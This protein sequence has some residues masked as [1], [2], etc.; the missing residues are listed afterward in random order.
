MS[1]IKHP[2]VDPDVT[3]HTPVP[4][5]IQYS[6]H[7]STTLGADTRFSSLASL[8]MS[9][10]TDTNALEKAQGPAQTRA[11]GTA[12][13]RDT[14]LGQVHTDIDNICQGVQALVDAN[15]GQAEEY[16]TAAAMHL[17]KS[18]RSPKPWLAAK[19]V[20]GTPGAALVKAKMVKKGASYEWQISS[21]G[22]TWT[23]VGFSTRAD[24]TVTGLSAGSTYSFRFR[25]TKGHVTGDFSQALTFMA[26]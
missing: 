2:L 12:A 21:D 8:V 9:L 17:R 11:K 14:P 13:A 19:M 5:V 10:V 23:T 15:P 16:A 4:E 20:P 3:R 24:M 18:N 22:K 25:T 1:T 26:H 6:R 7:L